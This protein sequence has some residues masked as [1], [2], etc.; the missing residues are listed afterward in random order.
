MAVALNDRD[1]MSFF[2][3]AGAQNAL[4]N[5]DGAKS[6]ARSS[7]ELKQRF[8]G[9]WFELGMAEWCGGKGNKTA[10]LNAFERARNDRTWRTMAEYEMDKVKNPQKYEN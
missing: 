2:R 9:A 10:A 6:A 1:A 8:G 4:G 5:C 3:L 7:T